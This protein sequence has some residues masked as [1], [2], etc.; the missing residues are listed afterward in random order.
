MGDRVAVVGD[1]REVEQ[2]ALRDDRRDLA[3]RENHDLVAP[4]HRNALQILAP[5]GRS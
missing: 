4:A 1:G 5:R 2:L 3:H